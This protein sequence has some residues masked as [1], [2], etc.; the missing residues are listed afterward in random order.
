MSGACQPSNFAQSVTSGS[1][2]VIEY[3]VES[4]TQNHPLTSASTNMY[5]DICTTHIKE[6][7]GA[8]F[9]E[10]KRASATVLLIPEEE[11]EVKHLCLVCI[12]LLNP[13]V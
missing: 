6:N 13:E 1:N 9:T 12:R 10:R 5:T 4:C 11:N 2:P 7:L 3:K 8:L